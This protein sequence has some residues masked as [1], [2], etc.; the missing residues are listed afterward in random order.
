MQEGK[1]DSV[2]IGNRQRAKVFDWQRAVPPERKTATTP[3][4]YFSMRKDITSNSRAV[5]RVLNAEFS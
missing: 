1:T 4:A 5:L 2:R 3:V